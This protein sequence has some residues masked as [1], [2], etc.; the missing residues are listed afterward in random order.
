MCDLSIHC[1]VWIR[2][3]RL[4]MRSLVY[5]LRAGSDTS[6]SSLPFLSTQQALSHR[7]PGEKEKLASERTDVEVA[8]VRWKFEIVG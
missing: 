5:N 8:L 1:E 6:L 2:G 7:L 4:S 3:R